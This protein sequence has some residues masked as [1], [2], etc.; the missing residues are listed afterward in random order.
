MF[1]MFSKTDKSEFLVT[2]VDGKLSWVYWEASYLLSAEAAEVNALA[3]AAQKRLTQLPCIEHK[4][5]QLKGRH[6]TTELSQPHRNF[7]GV[8]YGHGVYPRCFHILYTAF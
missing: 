8:H 4:T 3:Q 6:F 1:G 2:V 7:L 5:F